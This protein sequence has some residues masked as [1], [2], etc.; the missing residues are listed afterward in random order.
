MTIPLGVLPTDIQLACA[1]LRDHLQLIL[2]ENL[3]ALWVYGAVTFK[4]RPCRLGDIDTHAVIRSPLDPQTIHAIDDLHDST[5]RD[6]GVEWDSWYILERNTSSTAPPP[7][8]FR[9][10]LSDHAWA[11]HRAHWL[12]DQ[13]VALCGRTPSDLVRAPGQAELKDG[14]HSE[15]RFIERIVQQGPHGTG[16]AA[17]VVWQG[18]RIIY[19][20]RTRDIVVSKR[21]AA[22]WALEHLPDPFHAAVQAAERAYDAKPE[23]GDAVI[24]R[25]SLRP[26]LAACLEEFG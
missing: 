19:S 17:F 14:L 7:H 18:C 13:Y 23:P 24:L 12:A 9:A 5:G 16:H 8:A 21:A 10:G 22:H 3:I 15:M 20:L 25:A 1:Q 4:D 26:I 2:G 6:M 11:L